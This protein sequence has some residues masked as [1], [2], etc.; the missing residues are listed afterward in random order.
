[1]SGTSISTELNCCGNQFDDQFAFIYRETIESLSSQLRAGTCIVKSVGFKRWY[2]FIFT[3]YLRSN[4]QHSCQFNRVTRSCAL[5]AISSPLLL[6]SDG[7]TYDFKT[8][9][10]SCFYFSSHQGEITLLNLKKKIFLT[11]FFFLQAA[12]NFRCL[13]MLFKCI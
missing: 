2:C 1:M 9:Y 4:N 13:S 11:V 10:F 3:Q 8:Y 7:S 5:S 6:T 12:T